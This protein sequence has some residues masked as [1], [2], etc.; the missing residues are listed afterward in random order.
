MVVFGASRELMMT[1]FV[2]QVSLRLVHQGVRACDRDSN[3]KPHQVCCD[4][5]CRSWPKCFLK[6]EKECYYDTHCIKGA[7]CVKHECKPI[8]SRTSSCQTDADCRDYAKHADSPNNLHGRKCCGHKCIKAKDCHLFNLSTTARPIT[9]S[10]TTRQEHNSG[11]DCRNSSCTPIEVTE[12]S[13]LEKSANTLSRAGFLSAAILTA[14][15]FL[16]VMCCCF[17]RESKYISLRGYRTRQSASPYNSPCTNETAQIER[18]SAEQ[19]TQTDTDPSVF[20]VA[21]S[22]A[23]FPGLYGF[24]STGTGTDLPRPLACNLFRGPPSYHSVCLD[25]ELPPSYDEAVNL[26]PNHNPV[27]TDRTANASERRS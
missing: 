17:L 2:L 18:T 9:R 3:C 15:V 20:R 10:N 5:R 21:A 24:S 7:V 25:H 23:L 11:V 6:S 4:N 19:H 16:I 22:W 14:A 27:R 26:C 8:E 1:F 12:T 13:T